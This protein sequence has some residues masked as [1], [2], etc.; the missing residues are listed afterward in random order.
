MFE[1]G[2]GWV[3]WNEFTQK[4]ASSYFG[5]LGYFGPI[6]YPIDKWVSLKELSFFGN[7]HNSSNVQW[8]N[9]MGF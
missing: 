4:E 2:M 6:L 9:A 1:G 5:I 8:G 3:Y 7:A